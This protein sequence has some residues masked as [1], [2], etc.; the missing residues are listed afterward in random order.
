M[1][2]LL[3]FFHKSRLVVVSVSVPSRAPSL[4][5][6]PSVVAKAVRPSPR[7]TPRPVLR[8]SGDPVA[9]AQTLTVK[10]RPVLRYSF[11]SYSFP[12]FHPTT[13][14]KSFRQTVVTASRTRPVT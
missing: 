14:A 11:A 6:F 7:T 5:G 1:G 3:P 12:Y 4:C 13:G 2:S 9:H 10:L 8:F